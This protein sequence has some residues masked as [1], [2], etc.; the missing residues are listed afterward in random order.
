MW[1]TYLVHIIPNMN[2]SGTLHP[3][4]FPWGFLQFEHRLPPSPC[5]G[6]EEIGPGATTGPTPSFVFA[7]AQLMPTSGIIWTRFK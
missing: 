5:R 6:F 1:T 7:F 3:G 2:I 4:P